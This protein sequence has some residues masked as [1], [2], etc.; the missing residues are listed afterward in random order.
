MPLEQVPPYTTEHPMKVRDTD[1]G[2]VMQASYDSSANA[3]LDQV[4]ASLTQLIAV[5]QGIRARLD[6]GINTKTVT[7]LATVTL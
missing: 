3:K 4:A 6:A 5:M 7:T 2:A 1:T